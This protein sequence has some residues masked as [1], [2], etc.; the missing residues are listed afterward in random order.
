MKKWMICLLCVVILLGLAACKTSE[1]A[2]TQPLSVSNPSET[3]PSETVAPV[4]E[5][6]EGLTW[7]RDT[8]S[9]TET[10]RFLADGGFRYSCGC[11][12]PVNDADL[13]EGYAYDEESK[14][15]SLTYEETSD[16]TITQIVVVRCDGKTL[17][18]D[19]AGDVRTFHLA[20]N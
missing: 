20:E 15:I 3:E 13:C 1:P 10:I 4:F 9:C 12:N 14:L 11:G 7:T 8:E 17:V 16:E 2:Q 18:L 19:F 5:K 6:F